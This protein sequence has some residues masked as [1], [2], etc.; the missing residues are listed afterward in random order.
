MLGD[1]IVYGLS[2]WAVNRG[3]RWEAGA[4]L[5]KGALILGFF[6]FIVLEVIAKLANGVPPSS[7]VMLGFG[8]IA[9]AANLVCLALLWRF[10][11]LNINMKSTFACSRN[12]VA[13][14]IGVLVAAGGVA[15]PGCGW[16]DIVVGVVIALLFLK[17]AE[18]QQ[19]LVDAILVRVG[20]AMRRARVHDQPGVLD[21][22]CRLAAGDVDRH[23]LV[24]IAVDDQRRHIELLQV[25]AEIGGRER[26]DRIVGVLVAALHALRPPR[27]D[28]ALGHLR[29]RAVEAV[30]RARRDVLVQLRA[31]FHLRLADA[32][33]H[34]NRQTVGV[35]GGLQH[36][37][38][39][40]ADQHRL[41]HPAGAM[42]A[43]VARPFA[44]A[45]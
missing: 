38:R 45:G 15:L 19:V 27:I 33:E 34:F 28:Q 24:V 3:A 22:L 42:A 12:D 35:V 14:N 7:G 43:D 30:E 26:S 41:L 2:L 23:D 5:A 4:A 25:G 18:R 1:A 17:S 36:E 31:V 10:R 16:P 44:A 32:V 21:Q 20:Q 9:L 29:A 11:T 40:R 39:H 8:A 6:V 13:A 37:R